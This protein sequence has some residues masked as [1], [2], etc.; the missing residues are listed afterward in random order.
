MSPRSAAEVGDAER[1]LSEVASQ[2]RHVRTATDT[3]PR[4]VLGVWGA[5]QLVGFGVVAA[6][7]PVAGGAL[8]PLPVLAAIAVYAVLVAV[9]VV[10]TVRHTVA[11]QRGL[12]GP[13][14][15][16]RRMHGWSWP[17]AFNAG[18]ALVLAVGLAGA[19]TEVVMLLWPAL[20]GLLV[21][22]LYLAAAALWL[23][24]VRL[25]LGLWMLVVAVAAPFAGAPGNF[26]VMAV[27]GGGGFLVAA[28]AAAWWRRRTT[29][30]VG[31]A[32]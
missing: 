23:D 27:A 28:A 5:A 16:A 20:T 13:S 7:W 26:V 8:L 10:V 2:R 14:Q 19:G 3:D 29:G 32:S 31:V 6:S 9:A 21:G 4:L 11:V 24:P 18:A 22:L 25:G 15:R 1:L 30:T 17:V 12:D